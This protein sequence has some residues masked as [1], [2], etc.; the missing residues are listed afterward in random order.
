MFVLMCVF[1][2]ISL[3]FPINKWTFERFGAFWCDINRNG[4]RN[5]T[6]QSLRFWK[7][8]VVNALPTLGEKRKI[9]FHFDVLYDGRREEAHKS[10]V[11]LL[12]E[13]SGMLERDWCLSRREDPPQGSKIANGDGNPICG[14]GSGVGVGGGNGNA[15]PGSANRRMENMGT[16]L[17]QLATLIDW[18]SEVLVYLCICY[19]PWFI[20]V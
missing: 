1:V 12:L 5:S 6:R 19:I 10:I 16:L 2:I 14:A 17:E 3:R 4:N 20:V 18:G 9:V 8:F 13:F 7:Y 15:S 11:R